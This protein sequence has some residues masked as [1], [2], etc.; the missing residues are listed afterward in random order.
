MLDFSILLWRHSILS[1]NGQ[2]EGGR[3]RER[4]REREGERESVKRGGVCVS[5]NERA[6]I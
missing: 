1:L 4:E 5:N 6:A 2:K 3:E